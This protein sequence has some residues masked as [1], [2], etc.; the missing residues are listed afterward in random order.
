MLVEG[1]AVD[2]VGGL[3]GGE[4]EDGA[5]VCFGGGGLSC[6][7]AR[8]SR[9]RFVAFWGRGISCLVWGDVRS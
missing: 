2:C 8:R 7:R 4:E 5:G 3:F 9:F 6:R 1:V